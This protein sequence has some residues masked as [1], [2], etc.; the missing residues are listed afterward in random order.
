MAN[1]YAPRQHPG[2]SGKRNLT[3]ELWTGF[4]VQ[5]PVAEEEENLVRTTFHQVTRTYTVRPI[6]SQHVLQLQ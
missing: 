1:T 2:R 5:I 3:Y 4:K 6:S